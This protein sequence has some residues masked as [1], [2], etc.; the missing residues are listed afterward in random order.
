MRWLTWSFLD[1]FRDLGLLIMRVGMGL[2][3]VVHGW[4]KLAGGAVTWEKLGGTM[5]GLGITFFP[6]FWG[7]SA[8]IG[9]VLGGLLLAVGLATRPAAAV[10]AFTM[11]VAFKMHLDAGDEFRDYS[12][13]ME[14]MVVFVG[15]MFTGAGRYALD[16]RLRKGS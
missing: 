9:E 8:A 13:S 10:L 1:G 7:F 12:H 3:F 6:V 11:L 16:A 2:S 5:K 15:L 4:P 14:A